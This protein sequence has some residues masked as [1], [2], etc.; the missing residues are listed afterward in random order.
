MTAIKLIGPTIPA[1]WATEIIAAM[2]NHNEIWAGM[3]SAELKAE[4]EKIL[5]N[6]LKTYLRPIVKDY[7]EKDIS[8]IESNFM[9]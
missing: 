1:A 8:D 6:Q 2:R 9:D 5:K 4:L 7:R 3:V